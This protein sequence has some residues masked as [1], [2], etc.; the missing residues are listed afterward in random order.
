M[1][2]RKVSTPFQDLIRRE[3]LLFEDPSPLT[4]TNLQPKYT[5]RKKKVSIENRTPTTNIVDSSIQELP[6]EL[7]SIDPQ[8][9][10]DIINM[11]EEEWSTL[12]EAIVDQ[13]S[14]DQISSEKP[15]RKK[16]T[17]KENK[18]QLHKKAKQQSNNIELS[19]IN[20]S[21]HK[22]PPEFT[23][24]DHQYAENLIDMDEE[25]WKILEKAIND[26]TSV[27]EPT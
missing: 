19:D 22:T 9:I 11:N 25:T 5:S 21:T 7:S 23:P 27:K 26:Q 8:V 17:L 2:Q 12:K 4:S 1:C 18:S 6:P 24:T 16:R 13:E 3:Q 20:S 10:E 15:T 14:N